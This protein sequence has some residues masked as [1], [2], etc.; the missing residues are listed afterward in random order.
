MPRRNAGKPPISQEFEREVGICRSASG[1]GGSLFKG[2][3]NSEG[4]DL[5]SQPWT[6][7]ALSA[8]VIAAVQLNPCVCGPRC[9]ALPLKPR[10]SIPIRESR[11]TAN[12][13]LSF[14]LEKDHWVDLVIFQ[15][16]NVTERQ[17]WTMPRH[18]SD[19]R[20]SSPSFPL[21][22]SGSLSLAFLLLARVR[23]KKRA[24]FRE[25]TAAGAK[26]KWSWSF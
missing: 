5:K 17:Q 16:L 26:K 3:S 14:E 15:P 19:H 25:K 13:I 9:L 24:K 22:A 8:D 4:W 7:V 20:R 21:L 11:A 6:T 12:Y 23:G 18:S 2:A 10:D 1:N